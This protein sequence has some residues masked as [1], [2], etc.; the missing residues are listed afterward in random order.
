MH[1]VQ[2]ADKPCKVFDTFNQAVDDFFSSIGTQKLELKA[3]QIERDAMKKLENVKKDHT[4][5][6]VDL[7]KT[8]EF[9][10]HKAELI[11]RN[12]QLVDDAILS[13]QMAL[14]HQVFNARN[15]LFKWV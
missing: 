4:K 13:V 3:L 11:S 1:Y 7:E 5:R 9:D 12:Q 6:L 15:L 10:V 2:H 8:Q 14:A